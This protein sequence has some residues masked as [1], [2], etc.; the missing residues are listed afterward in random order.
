MNLRTRHE[1]WNHAVV[2]RAIQSKQFD[3]PNVAVTLRKEKCFCLL[4]P[5]WFVFDSLR[6]RVFLV[7]AMWATVAPC[8]RA[9]RVHTP[10]STRSDGGMLADTGG[11]LLQV[12]GDLDGR[13]LWSRL[14]ACFS[15]Q[16]S[17]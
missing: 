3:H 11:D 12:T 10:S 15:F 17:M 14:L 4:P 13:G 6:L 2:S 9:I 7:I 1:T 5:D 8:G 16:A